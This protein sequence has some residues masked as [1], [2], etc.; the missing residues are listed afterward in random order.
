M[1]AAIIIMPLISSALPLDVTHHNKTTPVII[2][3][4][5]SASS[6]YCPSLLSFS[7]PLYDHHQLGGSLQSV[8]LAGLFERQGQKGGQ[9]EREGEGKR[10]GKKGEYI[11][12][13]ISHRTIP[14]PSM[15]HH[16]IASVNTSLPP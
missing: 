2:V 13:T 7:L 9:R 14:P 15:Y 11:T 5:P 1:F 8:S 4:T 6:L 16:H 10:D 3:L 12:N